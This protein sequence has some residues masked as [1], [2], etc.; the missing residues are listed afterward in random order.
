MGINIASGNDVVTDQIGSVGRRV[1]AVDGADLEEALRDSTPRH[2]KPRETVNVRTGGARV[3]AQVDD[4]DVQ[5]V[6][7]L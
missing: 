6:R 3:G 2:G 5:V 7:E 1:T 4:I